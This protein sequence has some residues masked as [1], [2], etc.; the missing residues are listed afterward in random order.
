VGERE[1]GVEVIPS[2]TPEPGEG[3]TPYSL[4]EQ[5]RRVYLF[6]LVETATLLPHEQV[7]QE[8]LLILVKQ[9]ESDGALHSPV[10]VDRNSMVILDGHHRVKALK[11]LGC[12][13]TPVYLVDYSDPSIRVTQ[14]RDV[15]VSKR[16][17][18]EAGLSG[19]LYPPKV[20]RHVWRVPPRERPVP[21]SLLREFLSWA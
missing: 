17:V 18:V 19:R 20:S 3:A 7:E 10:I 1:R 16:E 12:A 13:L 8:R 4:Q 2:T 5:G 6:A 11:L 9:I 15:R 14:W 21:L